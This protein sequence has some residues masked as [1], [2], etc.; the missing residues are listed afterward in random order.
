MEKPS[1]RRFEKPRMRITVDDSDAPTTPDTAA[2]VVM[3]PSL[4][5]KIMSGRYF[6]VAARNTV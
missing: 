6:P 3:I 1:A 4:V 5:P 2:S